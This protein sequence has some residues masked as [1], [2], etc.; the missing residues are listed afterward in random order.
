MTIKQQQPV[1]IKQTDDKAWG[2]HSADDVKSS[3]TSLT[4][5]ATPAHVKC[6][7]YHVSTGV[8]VRGGVGMQEFM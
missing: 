7:S 2:D 8:I 3:D 1:I 5:H 4:V 6:Y